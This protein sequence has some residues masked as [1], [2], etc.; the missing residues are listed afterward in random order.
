M[1]YLLLLYNFFELLS[2]ALVY[3]SSHCV[4][5]FIV[6]L[7]SSCMSYFDSLIPTIV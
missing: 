7:L 5:E 1:T 2:F 6:Y 3:I 4:S